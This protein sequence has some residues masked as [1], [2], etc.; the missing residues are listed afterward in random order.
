MHC[1]KSENI[2]SNICYIL[3]L[4]KMFVLT[5]LSKFELLVPIL[6]N[7]HDVFYDLKN[8][9]QDTVLFPFFLDSVES[10]M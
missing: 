9:S 2:S 6:S 10:A 8:D 1:G 7:C 3:K 5:L 4:I